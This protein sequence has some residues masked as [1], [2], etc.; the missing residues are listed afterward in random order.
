MSGL[1]KRWI[2]I[3]G[4]ALLVAVLAFFV[5]SGFQ[6][7]FG[8]FRLIQ[9]EAQEATLRDQLSELHQERLGIENKTKRLS[10]EFLDLDLLD[11]RAR[12]VLGLA[13]GDEVII[14]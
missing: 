9:F 5:Y 4:S 13:R 2:G 6:G 11:E 10:N 1:G 12:A 7:E 3:S 14:R 8:L